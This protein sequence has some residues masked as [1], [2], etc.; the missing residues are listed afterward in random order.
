MLLGTSD[1]HA[2][3][4]EI[5]IGTK[6]GTEYVEKENLTFLK[7][8][9]CQVRQRVMTLKANLQSSSLPQASRGNGKFSYPYEQFSGTD[10]RP[11][12]IT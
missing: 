5:V 10:Q 8:Y 4:R 7:P 2:D 12:I 9:H 6:I 11:P 3:L 1:V